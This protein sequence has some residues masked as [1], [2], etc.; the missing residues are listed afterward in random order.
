VKRPNSVATADRAIWVA[1]EYLKSKVIF[2]T[3]KSA[4]GE[5]QP[6]VITGGTTPAE[7]AKWSGMTKLEADLALKL[8][9]ERGHARRR[10]DGR[11]FY[12]EP[13]KVEATEKGRNA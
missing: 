13:P 9:V 8:V 12:A 11:F 5:G 7:V 4:V 10:L 2:S 6:L 3:A 1:Y